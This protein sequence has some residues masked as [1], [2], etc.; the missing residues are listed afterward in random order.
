M[1]LQ[2]Q[3]VGDKIGHFSANNVHWSL[4][5]VEVDG[6]TNHCAAIPLHILDD[7]ITRE[8]FFESV[9]ATFVR[10]H[11]KENHNACLKEHST[12]MYS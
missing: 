12:K 4:I 8:A 3:D 11:H 2:V 6:H 7:F 10:T 5:V 9:D 1:D